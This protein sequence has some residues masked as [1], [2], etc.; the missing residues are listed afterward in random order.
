VRMIRKI[1]P[2]IRTVQ[3]AYNRERS[4]F[5]DSPGNFVGKTADLRGGGIA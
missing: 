5:H 4:L 3:C 2:S 1:D